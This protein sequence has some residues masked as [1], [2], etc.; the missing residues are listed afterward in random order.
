MAVSAMNWPLALPPWKVDFFV[1]QPSRSGGASLT[2]SEQII[3]SNA[4]RWRASV[5]LTIRGE[6]ANLALRA[7]VAALEGR[8]GTI[9]VPMWERYR[10]TDVNGRQLNPVPG[11]GYSCSDYN[12][13]VSGFEQSDAVFA[14]LAAN[15]AAG[16]TQISVDLIDV[17]G[18][19]PGHFF[20][21]ADR[22]HRCAAVWQEDEGDPTQIRFWPRLRAAASADATVILDRP[23]CLM[24]FQEDAAGDV[25]LSRAQTGAVKL[26]FV[27]AI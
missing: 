18:P 19:R 27:E 21:I 7:M 6:A 12:F 1:D 17:D 4:G 10:P 5:A 13:D 26:D 15:A 14:Q 16:A 23:V 8:A 9:L 25:A 11:A 24:R 2:G 22:I 3:V 20:G